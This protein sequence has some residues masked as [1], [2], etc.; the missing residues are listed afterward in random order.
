MFTNE[1]NLLCWY[2]SHYRLREMWAMN[3]LDVKLKLVMNRLYYKRVMSKVCQACCHSETSI[4]WQVTVWKYVL[5][6]TNDWSL[7]TRTWKTKN[8]RNL[9]I[10]RNMNRDRSWF[11]PF[12]TKHS[13]TFRM[14]RSMITSAKHLHR[15]FFRIG[16]VCWQKDLSKRRSRARTLTDF[17]SVCS[18]IQVWQEL[19]CLLLRP[20]SHISGTDRGWLSRQS[21]INFCLLFSFRVFALYF[22]L[23]G[24]AN[25][26]FTETWTH[27]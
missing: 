15:N 21:I 17:R 16:P 1:N 12:L 11:S 4:Q 26:F 25:S 23:R 20:D 2:L 22:F 19:G 9:I 10:L 7:G 13:G 27:V 8:Q 18:R 5:K 14:D 6:E 3:S 24:L